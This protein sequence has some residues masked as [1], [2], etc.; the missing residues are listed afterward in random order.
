MLSL[1]ALKPCCS[2]KGVLQSLRQ[3]SCTGFYDDPNQ[4]I[5]SKKSL[6]AAPALNWNLEFGEA[7]MGVSKQSELSSCRPFH[8]GWGLSGCPGGVNH[9]WLGFDSIALQR[10][11]R[12]VQRL[13]LLPVDL[14]HKSMAAT[15]AL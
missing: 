15:A 9:I 11:H 12:I 13:Q 3:S 14:I 6:Q 5:K 1:I 8:P 10:L 7:A 4:K 2:P